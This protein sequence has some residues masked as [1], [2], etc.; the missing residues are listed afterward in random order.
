MKTAEKVRIK[1][2][3]FEKGYVF[4]YS[5]LDISVSEGEALKKYIGRLVE[6]GKIARLSKG[7]FYKPKKG[8]TTNLKPDEYEVVKDLLI[9]GNK[10]VGY[11]TGYSVFNSFKLT[12]QVPNVIQI[13]TNFDKKSIRRNIYTVKFVRQWNKITR[14]NIPLLQLLDCIRFIKSIPDTTI[15]NAL[16]RITVLLNE[17]SDSEKKQ[18]IQL[19]INY[20]PS[21]RALTGAIFELLGYAEKADKLLN[22]L[23]STSWYDFNI[24]KD[25][26]PNKLKWKI[27]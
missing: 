7:R 11:I 10:I 4:T 17:L 20:P 19:A 5:D 3:K 26:L 6:S 2:D 8:I 1:I 15:E 12:T 24:T 14:A 21:T 13:G 16:N 18:C 9:A 25:Q 23:K 22:T 27:K